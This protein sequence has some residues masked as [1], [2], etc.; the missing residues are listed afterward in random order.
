MSVKEKILSLFV[1]LGELANPV[2]SSEGVKP[3]GETLFRY[4][5]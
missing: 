2:A 1:L 5:L 4:Y 3:R